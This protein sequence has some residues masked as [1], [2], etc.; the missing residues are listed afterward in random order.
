MQP[1]SPW[2]IGNKLEFYVHE[3]IELIDWLIDLEI[4]KIQKVC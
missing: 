1:F 4:K 2:N 3:D